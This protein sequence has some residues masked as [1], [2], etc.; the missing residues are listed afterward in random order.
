MKAEFLE[1]KKNSTMGMAE[2]YWWNIL[3]CTEGKDE[4]FKIFGRGSSNVFLDLK[5]SLSNVINQPLIETYFIRNC[6]YSSLPFCII[7]PYVLVCYIFLYYKKSKTDGKCILHITIIV[8]NG[9]WWSW[10]L[11]GTQSWKNM[12]NSYVF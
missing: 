5:G 1:R 10:N 6:Y 8:Q 9:K 7:S 2:I 12:I 4:D 11:E 3:V